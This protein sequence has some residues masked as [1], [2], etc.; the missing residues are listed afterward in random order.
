MSGINDALAWLDNKRKVVATNVSDI[1]RNPRDAIPMQ[2]T[3][4]AE[5]LTTQFQDPMNV[6]GH[7]MGG[8]VGSLMFKPKTVGDAM[9]MLGRYEGDLGRVNSRFVQSNL[10]GD[11][12]GKKLDLEDR[13]ELVSDIDELKAILQALRNK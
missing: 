7:G 13:T 2:A 1:L 12:F 9:S 5:D 11:K 6:V 10:E 3:R 8:G 4:A